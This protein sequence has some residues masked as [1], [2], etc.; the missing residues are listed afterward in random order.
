MRR[1]FPVALAALVVVSAA[2]VAGALRK[3]PSAAHRAHRADSLGHVPIILHGET[4]S[5]RFGDPVACAGDVNGDGRDDLIVGAALFN[6]VGQRSG[7]AYVYLGSAVGIDTLPVW[8]RASQHPDAR[9]GVSVAGVGDLDGDGYDEIMVGACRD[10][11]EQEGRAYLYRGGPAGPDTIPAWVGRGLYTYSAFGTCVASAGDV[12][13]DGLPDVA[14]GAPGRPGPAGRA[15]AVQVYYGNGTGL[16]PTPTLITGDLDGSWFGYSVAN[17]GD[18][19]ADG[20]DDLVVGAVYASNPITWEGR[21]YVYLG[22]ASG[23]STTPAWV[24][25]GENPGASFGFNVG[26]AGD[27]DADGLADVLIGAHHYDTTLVETLEGTGRAFLYRGTPTGLT[28][29]APWWITGR[30]KQAHL[31]RS[32]G[33]AGDVNGDGVDDMFVTTLRYTG[34]QFSEGKLEVFYGHAGTGP[35]TIADWSYQ[36][37]VQVLALGQS[38]VANM[39]LN[40]D[41]AID[42]AAGSSGPSEDIAQVL[43]WVY[44]ILGVPGP[45][46]VPP[47]E[48]LPA[49]PT[50]FP[51]PLRAGAEGG[52]RLTLPESGRVRVSLFDAQG[53]EVARLADGS[54]AAGPLT[55]RFSGRGTAGEPL[56]PGLYFVR[57]ATGGR[58][59][60]ARLAVVR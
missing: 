59:F 42:I 33:C 3:P 54:F 41:G 14:I 23:V 56:A 22:S 39:D 4:L 58:T 40:G 19:N 25:D 10:S 38:M 20:F 17:A 6:G 36:P 5:D 8:S 44:V 11:I 26:G 37:G 60:G 52:V 7:K 9:F 45:L 30:S 27:V 53:R 35:S 12:N 43:G 51:N 16:S 21:A 24:A 57:V 47:A 29:E 2:P 46:S 1:L 18:V 49:P 28:A 31:G 15:G 13:G 50:A 34:S 55:L 32:V 48:I